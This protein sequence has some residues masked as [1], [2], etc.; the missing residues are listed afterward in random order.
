L[1]LLKA[2]E[3]IKAPI[4]DFAFLGELSLDGEIRKCTG[5]LPMVL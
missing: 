1:R 3:Q 2:T 5:V 4:E